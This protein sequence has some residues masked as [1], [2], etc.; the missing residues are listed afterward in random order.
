[1]VNW[2]AFIWSVNAGSM[3][4]P[5]SMDRF[6]NC[7]VICADAGLIVYVKENIA[8][9]IRAKRRAADATVLFELFWNIV[10]LSASLQFY[11]GSGPCHHYNPC[12]GSNCYGKWNRELWCDYCSICCREIRL[13]SSIYNIVDL[14]VRCVLVY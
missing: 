13:Y 5:S 8:M 6:P 10:F 3:F 14:V 1:M 12:K 2:A 7:F 4:Q 11:S 9:A